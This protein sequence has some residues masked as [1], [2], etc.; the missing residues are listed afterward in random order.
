MN[1]GVSSSNHWVTI[2]AQ[3]KSLARSTV[4]ISYDA[5]GRKFSGHTENVARL[6]IRTSAFPVSGRPVVELDGDPLDLE[7]QNGSVRLERR[8]G[9]WMAAGAQSAG[10]AKN[11]RRAGPFKEAFQH[12]MIYVYG[13]QGNTAENAWA[14]GKARYDAET[15]WYR[16]NGAV[17]LIPDTEFDP[18]AEPDRSVILYGNSEINRAWSAL[19]QDSPV[20]VTRKAVKIGGR[21]I[22]GPELACFFVRPRPGSEIASVAVI[23]ATGLNGLRLTERVPYFLAGVGFPDCTVFD[24]ETLREEIKGVRA[25][26]FFG[27]DW[28]VEKGEFAWRE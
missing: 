13:T 4:E 14:L 27:T 20:Q 17:D 26:G 1:L 10:Q 21:E 28:S 8:D 2:E 12:R 25:A 18:A 7:P 15:W 11:P 3:E 23:G 5:S 9:H 6:A 19:L 22:S 24:V 16:G